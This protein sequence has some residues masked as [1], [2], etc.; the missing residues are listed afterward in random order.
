[1]NKK[2]IFILLLITVAGFVAC[3]QEA[4]TMF[5]QPDGIYFNA[6]ADSILYSFAKYPSRLVDTVKIPVTVLGNPA[7][8]DRDISIQPLTGSDVNAIQGVHY[9]LLP[10]YEMPANQVTT[11]IPVVVY[12][13]GDLD[14]ITM[15]IKLG[16][17]ANSSF[18]LGIT[19]KTTIKI[20]TAYLQKPP[21]WGEYTGLQWAGY[22]AN[23]GT[24]T[25]TK[26]KLVL[27]ALYDPTSDTTITEFPYNR[28]QPPA[29]YTQYLQLVKNYVRT[30][31][32]GNY[33]TPIGV[34]ATL[35]D[36]DANNAVIQVG[37]ANY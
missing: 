15:T 6:S 33:S 10:P 24:W 28:L 27:D 9:K 11:K 16:V 26:Y 19:S 32:P 35:R 4:P 36:P 31:Y 5:S 34:G 14:S 12:R 29:I 17:Q 8:T 37:P 2:T 23:F 7:S 13:T 18:A 1:M 20:K 22:S 30:K 25:K 21:S 3:K